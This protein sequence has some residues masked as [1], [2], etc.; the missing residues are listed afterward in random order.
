EEL[1]DGTGD[2][3]T[4]AAESTRFILLV[5]DN[6]DDEARIRRLLRGQRRTYE[7]TSCATGA[8]ALDV[9]RRD[10]LRF[11]CVLLDYHLSDMN[12][13]EFLQQVRGPAGVPVPV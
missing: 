7:I 11:D 1:P 3:M 10:G 6:V 4:T 12:G 8:E 5:E 2:R 13:L 9:V